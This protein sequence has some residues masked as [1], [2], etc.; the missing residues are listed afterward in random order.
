[1]YRMFYNCKKLKY[2]NI[3]NLIE[4]VQSITEM[5]EGASN[6]FTICIKENENIPNI[7]NSIYNKITRDCSINCYG[8]GKSRIPSKNKKLCCNSFVYNNECLNKCPPK[9]KIQD[10]TKECKYFSCPHFYNYEQDD[11]IDN[12]TDGFYQND[13]N[14][15]DKCHEDCKT[16]SIGPND[17]STN[18]LICNGNKPYAF[19]GNCSK[20]CPNGYFYDL[21]GIK[22][23]K[24]HKSKCKECTKE[25][26][27]YDLC[28]SCNEDEGYYE[29]SYDNI[30]TFSFRNCYKELE[31]YYLNLI[32]KKYIPCY[33]SCKSCA[34][35]DY[36]KIHH[37]CTS[38][39]EQNSFSIVEENNPTLMN[40]YPECKF[41]FFFDKNNDYTCT[42]TAMCPQKY[43]FLIENT[44]QC[45]ETCKNLKKIWQFRHTCFEQCPY[46]SKNYTNSSGSYCNASC[47]FERPFEMVETQYCVSSCTIME[48]YDKLCFTNYDGDRNREV[49]D[50]VLLDFRDD[51]TDKFNYSFITKNQNL[52]HEERNA[53]FEITSTQ[54]KYENQKTTTIDLGECE[55]ILKNYSKIELNKALYIL[56]IDAFV[57]GKTIPNVEYEIYYPNNDKKLRQLDLS[58]CESKEIFIGYPINIVEFELDQYDINSPFYNDIC[59][60]YSNSKGTDVTLNDR[61]IEY[62]NSNKNLCEE[63]CKPIR[64]DKEKRRLICSCE[65]KFIIS[66]ISQIKEDKNNLFKFID[67]RQMTN[68][69]VMKCWKLLF[70][71]KGLKANIGFYSFFPTII[72]YIISLFIFFPIEFKRINKQIDE[73]I[74][75]KQLIKYFKHNKQQNN[76]NNFFKIFLDKKKINFITIKEKKITAFYNGDIKN[77]DKPIKN[78]KILSKRNKKYKNIDNSSSNSKTE[79]VLINKSIDNI[80]YKEE[81]K[82]SS[83]IVIKKEFDRKIKKTISS[84][85]LKKFND[86]AKF[87]KKI[88]YSKKFEE[89]NNLTSK[90]LSEASSVL[91]INK[92]KQ[93]ELTD[94]QKIKIKQILKYNDNELN[95]LGYTKAFKFD[96]RTLFQ[97]YISLLFTK[98]I[99]FQ[100]FNTKDYNSYSIKVLLLFFN[101]S[102]CFAMNTLFF[103]DNTIH[104]IYKDEGDFNFIYQLPQ[105][106]YSTLIS[107]FI[108]N[109]TSYLAL[110]EDNI[111]ELKKDKSLENLS[112]KIRQI[113]NTLIIKFISFFIVNI[114]FILLFWYYLSCFCAV[115]VNSQYH[116]IK[117]TLISFGINY[118]MPIGTNILTALLRNYSLKGYNKNKRL[119][120]RL[121][122]LLQQYL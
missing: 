44:K 20:S 29:K 104:Q 73:I 48:R 113:K 60:P 5:F 108:D 66:M 33:H 61:Q 46:D 98:H 11:C 111:I 27:K 82:K 78:L 35:L 71:T 52:I 45:I 3:F 70:S 41:N 53:I 83:N 15:I 1:M 4:D 42:E 43:P 24:C 69:N 58:I 95:D 79:K 85:P 74:S 81:N 116:L 112:E 18:C 51:I 28:V 107:Y 87:E 119:L 76:E 34:P 38:C 84:P 19:L 32:Q 21:E 90:N 6:D 94:H 110:C 100:I 9:T 40:C 57:E 16:C 96:H 80:I 36:N 56:K 67:L 12:I 77:N 30:N 25:S 55:E 106:A 26:L 59:H 10:S 88:N 99:F 120:F 105:I 92:M 117:D 115:Y 118:I 64:Y 101:F 102:S 114:F 37:Y 47:P 122:K 7:Y 22:R 31:G 93:E 63:N 86:K 54:C 68:F 62:I 72:S 65:I 91:K 23:C 109:L 75:A 89:E 103:N 14:T 97:Y 49:Q 39:N 50:M 13:T 17:Y 2:L 121:S 8:Q